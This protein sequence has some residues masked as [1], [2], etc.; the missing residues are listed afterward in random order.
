MSDA[1]SR[2]EII[3]ELT[4]KKLSMIDEIAK[5]NTQ[6]IGNIAAVKTQERNN[7]RQLEDMKANNEVN[8]T[9]VDGKQIELQKKIDAIDDSIKAIKAISANNEKTKTESK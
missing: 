6:V 7:I 1:K 3:D 9:A 5:L 2:Y 8:K 4:D